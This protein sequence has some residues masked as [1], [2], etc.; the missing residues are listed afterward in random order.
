[1]NVNELKISPLLLP[2]IVQSVRIGMLSANF[3]QDRRDDPTD[4]HKGMY[5]TLEFGYASRAFGSQAE[6]IRLLV[7][8][9]TY[10]RITKKIILARETSFG[11][12]PA[13]RVAANTDA[14]DPIPLPERFY[15][16]GGNSLRAFPENQAGPRDPATGFPLG[17][18]ALFFNNTEVR[19][20]L[21]GETINGVLFHDMG[22]VFDKL[23]NMSLRFN[24]KNATDFG[25]TVHAVGAGV[26]YRTPIGP[27]RLDLA[28]SVNPPKFNG[29]GGTYEQLVQCSVNGTCGSPTL[30]RVSHFQ[31][32]FSIGQ[33]F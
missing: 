9:A 29:F 28:Y 1:V 6:F 19:F 16:G 5:N 22:N 7:R 10:H 4:A 33:A 13:F 3:I 24:Q 8:N 17:G 2:H 20:P 12:Q 14:S 31:F 25:Y 30:Q 18:S 15:G 32:F 27:L 21:I 11:V 26:R 23:S